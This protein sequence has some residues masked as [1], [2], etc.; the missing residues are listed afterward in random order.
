MS[1]FPPPPPPPVQPTAPS[2]TAYASW[3]ARVGATLLDGL[4]ALAVM[5]PFVIVGVPMMVMGIE[6]GEIDPVTGYT[7]GGSVDAIGGLGIA[8]LV[9]GYAAIFVFA[10]WNYVVRQGRTGQTLGKKWVGIT[11][12]KEQT[13]AAPGWPS[14]LGRYFLQS[15][16]TTFTLYL[17]V[18]WPLWDDKRQTLHDK[19][20]GT[21]VLKG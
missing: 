5:I 20:L 1:D 17:N 12:I 4:I 8:I 21:V 18:L 10:I 9:L 7:T 3:L 16:L 15:I 6:S 11:L 14:C 19:V 2:T 13:G